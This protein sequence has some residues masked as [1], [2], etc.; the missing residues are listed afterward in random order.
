MV[1]RDISMYTNSVVS[2]CV[3][4]CLNFIYSY[5]HE[6]H[7]YTSMTSCLLDSLNATSNTFSL[8]KGVVVVEVNHCFRSLFGTK[9]LLK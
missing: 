1:V 9:G 6:Q 4:F 3:N 5:S 2:F 8:Q 7:N